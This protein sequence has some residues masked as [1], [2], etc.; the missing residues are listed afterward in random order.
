MV[1][2]LEGSNQG[3]YGA[4]ITELGQGFA[5]SV[6]TWESLSWRAAI[7]GSTA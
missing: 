1:L 3:F 5:A 2:S 4:C 6:R 7:R